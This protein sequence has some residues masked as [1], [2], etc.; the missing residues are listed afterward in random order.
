MYELSAADFRFLCSLVYEHSGIVLGEAK[1][2]M[3]YRRIM[4]RIRILKIDSFAGYCNYIRRNAQQELPAF[5]NAVT[6]NLTRFFR[7]YHHFEYLKQEYLPQLK[8]AGSG[9][10]RLWS[11]GCSTGEEAYSLAM[12][13]RSVF[14]D[15]ELDDKLILATD[16]DTEV[17][18]VASQGCYPMSAVKDI[19]PAEQARYFLKD[20]RNALC[21]VKPEISTLIRFR[22]LN[23]LNEWPMRGQF[24]VIFCRN[25]LIYFDR[26]TQYQV[27][28][29]LAQRLHS[30]G[31]LCLGHSESL[32]RRVMGLVPVGRTMFR[33]Q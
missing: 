32:D 9:R 23:L 24:D 3:L 25:V 2:H 5:I 33:R 1:R 14:A 4:R 27:V 13:L 15:H 16:L 29:R 31:L 6:T 19:A 7:E 20:K 22:Q 11:A 17:L 18:D 12:C 10:V 21:K 30:G 26:E 8:R 28:S